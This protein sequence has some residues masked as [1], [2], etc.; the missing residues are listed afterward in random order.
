MI[1]GNILEFSEYLS[2]VLGSW[3]GGRQTGGRDSR[4]STFGVARYAGTASYAAEMG[5]SELQPTRNA[6]GLG[7][8]RSGILHLGMFL[9]LAVFSVRRSSSAS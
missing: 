2:L 5:R 9:R 8:V 1:A 7:I 6:Q 4:I 3:S